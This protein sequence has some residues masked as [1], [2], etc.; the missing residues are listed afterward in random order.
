MEKY[1]PSNDPVICNCLLS[2]REYSVHP[3][4][5]QENFLSITYGGYRRQKNA[6]KTTNK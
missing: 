6:S 3:A 2:T 5:V 4:Y 1:V